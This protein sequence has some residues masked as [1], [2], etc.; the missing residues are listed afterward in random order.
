MRSLGLL[1]IMV[2]LVLLALEHLNLIDIF[3]V[4]GLIAGLYMVMFPDK[5]QS[6]I[7]KLKAADQD[8]PTKPL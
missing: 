8:K 1:I 4:V 3:C 2:C 7:E 6:F 5:A